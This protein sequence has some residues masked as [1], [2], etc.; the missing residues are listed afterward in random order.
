MEKT[1]SNGDRLLISVFNKNKVKRGDVVVF[2]KDNTFFV[3]R[4]VGIPGDSVKIVDG[5]FEASNSIGDL[6][7]IDLNSKISLSE[8]NC[9]TNFNPFFGQVYKQDWDSYNFGPLY[10]PRFEDSVSSEMY[11]T[12]SHLEEFIVRKDNLGNSH[13]GFN[14]SFYFFVGDNVCNSDDSRSV[15]LIAGSEIIGIGY[16]VYSKANRSLKLI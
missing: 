4:C 12:Y 3:K 8:I 11:N 14:E 16:L 1:L 5:R 7:Q 13:V 6:Y 15:G 9:L 10:L 2:K